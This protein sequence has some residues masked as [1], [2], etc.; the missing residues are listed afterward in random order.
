MFKLGLQKALHYTTPIIICTKTVGGKCSAGFGSAI[1]VNTDGW[2]VT[3]KHIFDG[4]GELNKGVKAYNDHQEKRKEI[5]GQGLNRNQKKRALRQLGKLRPTDLT[6][7][8]FMWGQTMNPQDLVYHLHPAVDLA[9][10]QVPNFP[11]D[12]IE[13]PK[14]RTQDLSQGEMLCRL[15]FPL[16]EVSIEWDSTDGLFKLPSNLF[17]VPTFAN[18]GIVSR[19][20]TVNGNIEHQ[21]IET[22]SPGLK[23]QSGGPL[24][25]SNGN[26]CGVQSATRHYSLG[27]EP[28]INGKAEHQFLN[29]GHAVHVKTVIPFMEECE[30]TFE[31]EDI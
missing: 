3:A 16:H 6:N 26:I 4:F 25:D 23:G 20:A 9:L 28:K 17:P 11:T 7:W 19:F 1:M 24:I 2:F 13:M 31:S 10:I 15:G 18:E 12:G 8:L 29:V 30:V 21:I 5:D 27:F 22:S 14:F